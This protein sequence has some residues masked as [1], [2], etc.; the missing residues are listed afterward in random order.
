MGKAT[1]EL[2]DATT[3]ELASGDTLTRLELSAIE[4]LGV[5]VAVAR[6]TAE[7]RSKGKREEEA[8]I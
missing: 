3:L 7:M 8:A 6:M 5:G 4:T 1:E 2:A